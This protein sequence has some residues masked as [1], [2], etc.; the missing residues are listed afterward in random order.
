[1]TLI[2]TDW[3]PFGYESLDRFVSYPSTFCGRQNAQT[4]REVGLLDDTSVCCDMAML[5]I[6]STKR[7]IY[8]RLYKSAHTNEYRSRNLVAVMRGVFLK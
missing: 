7:H 4:D 3:R 8:G 2:F 1:M 5:C 6:R